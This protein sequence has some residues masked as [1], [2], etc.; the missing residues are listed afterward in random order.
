MF[1]IVLKYRSETNMDNSYFWHIS[2]KNLL[3]FHT[4]IWNSLYCSVAQS[5]LTLCDP[6]D[7]STPDFSVP[8]HFPELAQA[9]CPLSRWDHPTISSSCVQS[10]W[11][12]G[13]FPVSHFFTSGGQII[14]TSA[15][16]SVLP[17]N[18]QDWFYI[19]EGSWNYFSLKYFIIRKG[20]KE[21]KWIKQ[22]EFNLLDSS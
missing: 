3:I 22:V 9:P 11:T 4:F 7:C 1:Y 20:K 19:Y 12:S 5:C 13:S 6:M 14:G 21:L 2:R 15:S 17:M 16:A 10:F 18:I 8:H